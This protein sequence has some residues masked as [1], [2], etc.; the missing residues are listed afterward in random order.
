MVG[1]CFNSASE[2]TLLEYLIKY[3]AICFNT[4]LTIGMAKWLIFILMQLQQAMIEKYKTCNETII[5]MME[6]LSDIER[7]LAEQEPVS[8]SANGLRNQ[9]NLLKVTDLLQERW[10]DR[11]NL[12]LQLDFLGNCKIFNVF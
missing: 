4:S 3:E 10:L 11:K 5:T 1:F 8:E 12:N 6:N 7:R 2:N 9:I